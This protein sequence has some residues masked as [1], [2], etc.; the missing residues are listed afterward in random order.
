MTSYN[1]IKPLKYYERLA[2]D[3]FSIIKKT[4]EQDDEFITPE[5]TIHMIQRRELCLTLLKRTRQSQIEDNT[6]GHQVI[7]KHSYAYWKLKQLKHR[8]KTLKRV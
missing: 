2:D 8:T 4:S 1:I 5:I 7:K 6:R 3:T